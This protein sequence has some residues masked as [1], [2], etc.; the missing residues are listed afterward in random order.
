VDLR[1]NSSLENLL[2]K[3][4]TVGLLIFVLISAKS[5][6]ELFLLTFIFTYFFSHIQNFIHKYINKVFRVPRFIVT[7]LIYSVI[8]GFIVLFLIKYIPVLSSQLTAVIN[9]IANFNIANYQDKLDS[10]LV[11]VIK[12]INI[13]PYVKEGSTYLLQTMADVGK[14]SLNILLALFLSLLFILGYEEIIKF[15]HKLEISKASY[16]Y[17]NFQYFGRNFLNSFGKVMEVQIVFSLINA[18]A[19]LIILFFMGFPQV[20]GLAFMIFILGLIPVAGVIISLIPLCI[21]GFIIGGIVKVIYVLVMIAVLHFLGGYILYPKLAAAKMR[22][23]I[24][25]TFIILILGEHFLGVWGLLIGI[26]LFMF[27]LDLAEVKL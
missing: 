14:L 10:R 4:I 22:L 12:N 27:L 2:K 18:A 8:T 20:L 3:V 15:G 16:L 21:I 17:H 19:S 24:F 7:T 25:L 6:M 13:A 11:E 5:V 9:Q 26:P 1:D 23:P